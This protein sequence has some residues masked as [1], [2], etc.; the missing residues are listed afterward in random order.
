MLGAAIVSCGNT[1]AD[2][3]SMS[4]RSSSSEDEDQPTSVRTKIKK[5][6]CQPKARKFSVTFENFR[7]LPAVKNR[8]VQSSK[9]AC[10]GHDWRLQLF[11]GGYSDYPTPP[12]GAVGVCVERSNQTGK[13]P[14]VKFLFELRS[15]DGNIS[16]QTSGDPSSYK[17][18]SNTSN[19]CALTTRPDIKHRFLDD[20]RALTISV[21]LEIN[22]FV[23][24]NPLAATMLKLFGDEESSDVIFEITKKEEKQ[25]NEEGRWHRHQFNFMRIVSFLSTHP[26]NLLHFVSH[27][28]RGG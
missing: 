2:D 4:G 19:I 18:Y 14:N 16:L 1:M 17:C 23:P 27:L 11:P 28:Q 10:F 21:V 25:K 7:D 8:G 3:N 12:K 5:E 26:L 13:W 22:E 20:K 9:F 24:K 6:P 15:S